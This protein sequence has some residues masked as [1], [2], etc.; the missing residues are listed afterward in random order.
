MIL[1]ADSSLESKNREQTTM[2]CDAQAENDGK[3]VKLF[4]R[5]TM[6]WPNRIMTML[7]ATVAF[8]AEG[9]QPDSFAYPHNPSQ[10]K[11]N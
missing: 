8:S 11:S 4:C 2:L 7:E 9:S 6:D 1:N 5:F 10:A 3:T